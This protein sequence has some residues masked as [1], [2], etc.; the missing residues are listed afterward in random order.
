[1]EGMKV[2]IDKHLN[3]PPPTME[4]GKIPPVVSFRSM[5]ELEDAQK[6]YRG[7]FVKFFDPFCTHCIR[8]APAFERLGA[9]F[10]GTDVKVAE[11][12]CPQHYEICGQQGIRSF[13]T[14]FLYLNGRLLEYRG[15]RETDDMKNFLDSHMKLTAPKDVFVT[16]ITVIHT[17]PAFLETINNSEA[18][19]VNFYNPEDPNSLQFTETYIRLAEAFT[20]NGKV[21]IAE[22][23]CSE[24]DLCRVNGVLSFPTIKMY[25]R[26]RATPYSGDRSLDDLKKFVT[27]YIE[28]KK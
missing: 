5:K 26:G 13:P 24:N 18:I 25:T 19:L 6:F 16:P 27:D 11:I 12:N 4:I 1:M 8:M 3:G 22:L 15:N 28:G 7:V 10:V 20:N 23:D 2:F 14:M 21:K 17:Q 9:E